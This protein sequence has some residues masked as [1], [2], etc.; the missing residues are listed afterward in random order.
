MFAAKEEKK[1]KELA[2]QGSVGSQTSLERKSSFGRQMSG[3]SSE[4]S[5]H[6]SFD[7]QQSEGGS[8]MLLSSS[9]NSGLKNILA[10]QKT[11]H[12]FSLLPEELLLD[13]HLLADYGWYRSLRHYVLCNTFQSF[14][15]CLIVVS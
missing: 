6:S 14:I 15:L 5:K 7:R 2:R 11:Q 12:S 4:K 3:N 10:T 9:N 13:D 1:E 8:I